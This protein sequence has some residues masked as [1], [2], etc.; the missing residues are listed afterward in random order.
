MATAPETRAP[1]TN[2]TEDSKTI[3]I[4]LSATFELKQTV[5]SIQ[6]TMF[7]EYVKTLEEW[8]HSVLEEV[9]MEVEEDK[10]KELL[11]DSIH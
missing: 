7:I 6:H 1:V 8:E 2:A 5:P 10:L 11:Q 3:H 9:D 4:I